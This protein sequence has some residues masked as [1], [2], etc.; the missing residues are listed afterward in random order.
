LRCPFGCREAHRRQ[1]SNERSVEYYRTPE[2]KIKKKA[3]NANRY[4]K[5]FIKNSCD[6]DK[7]SVDKE[8]VEEDVEKNVEFEDVD[9]EPVYYKIG[10]Y[11]LSNETLDYLSKITSFIEGRFVSP[12][13]IL[14]ILKKKER[15]HSIA[16]GESRNFN[17]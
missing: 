8:D 1:R 10:E 14:S 5:N 15:Q 13:D 9:K 16:K 4:K 12:E 17:I 2:G 3:L 6:F 7:N 11:N